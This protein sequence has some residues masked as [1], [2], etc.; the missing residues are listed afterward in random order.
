[1]ENKVKVWIARDKSGELFLSS[2]SPTKE[3]D[4]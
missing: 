1:M 4:I 2:E 3:K